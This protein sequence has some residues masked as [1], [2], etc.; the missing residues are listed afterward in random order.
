[1]GAKVTSAT[2]EPMAPMTGTRERSTLNEIREKRMETREGYQPAGRA[3]GAL[4]AGRAQG[5]FT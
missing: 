1:M 3:Q 2:A 5:A 4:T